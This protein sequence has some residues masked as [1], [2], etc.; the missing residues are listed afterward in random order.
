MTLSAE[1]D[2]QFMLMAL[3]QARDALQ[4][5]ELPFGAV[6]VASDRLEIVGAASNSEVSDG[7]VTA[8]AELKAVREA[9]R[10]IGGPEDLFGLTL[11]ATAEPCVMCAGAIFHA[12]IARV[13]VALPRGDFPP[14]FRQRRIG[15]AELS[16]DSG[17]PIELETGLCRDEAADLLDRALARRL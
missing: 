10:A 3:E 5:G 15:F 11:Y 16:R 2:R 6:V 9:M 12:K 7:D 8:H 1:H 17:Y 4:H 13:V 14:A